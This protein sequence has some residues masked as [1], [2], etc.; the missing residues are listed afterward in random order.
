VSQ[1][2]VYTVQ[3]NWPSPSTPT[4]TMTFTQYGITD[5]TVQ[6][7]DGSAWQ[8]LGTVTGNNLVKRT[9]TFSTTFTTSK[10]RIVV[11]NAINS[12][13]RITSVE[14]WGVPAPTNVALASSGA[15][16]SASSQFSA[17]FPA[18]A[19]IDG[20][21]KGLNWSAEGGWADGTS[22]SYPDWLEVDFPAAKT[23]DHVI[24]F[25][26]QDNWQSPS[27]PTD[28]M[29]FTQ[30]GIVDFSVQGWDGTQWVTLGSVTGNNLVKRTISFPAFTTSKIRVN[31]TSSLSDL[32]RITEVEAYGW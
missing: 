9:V 14:A 16:A 3:D 32:S 11:N 22:D 21:E 6:G 17:S 26:L 29:T 28:T 31:V 12:L 27:A 1:V 20:D 19:A 24:V 23:L 8:V 2:V 5:F 25:T 10:I 4:D 7:W 15:T 30:Y 13:S 18:A